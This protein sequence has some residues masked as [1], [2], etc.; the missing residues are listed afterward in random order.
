LVRAALASVGVLSSR[1]SA[2][3]AAVRVQR[4]FILGSSV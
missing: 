3:V 2:S 1:R 4:R